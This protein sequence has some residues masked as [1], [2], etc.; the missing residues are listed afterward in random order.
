VRVTAF[1]ANRRTKQKAEGRW[2]HRR[3]PQD[4]H[5]GVNLIAPAASIVERLKISAS[6]RH[7]SSP[8]YGWL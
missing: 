1:I 4:S 5:S 8:K 3:S 7:A 6:S 2:G